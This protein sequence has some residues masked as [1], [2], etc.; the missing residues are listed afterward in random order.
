MEIKRVGAQA[1][2]RGP[3]DYFTGMVRVDM[4]FDAPDPARVA[5]LSYLRLTTFAGTGSSVQALVARYVRITGWSAS[6]WTCRWPGTESV[7]FICTVVGSTVIR[8]GQITTSQM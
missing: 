2:G 1:S 4:L 7:L 5:F 3:A 6:L 8:N